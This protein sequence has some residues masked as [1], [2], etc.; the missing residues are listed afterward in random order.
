MI[1]VIVPVYNGED[2]IAAALRSIL[3]QTLAP[4]EVIVVDDGSTDRSAEIASGFGPPIRVLRQANCGTAM[5]TNAGLAEA[6]GELLAFLDADDLWADE[7][8]ALQ[9]SALASNSQLE[10]VFGGVVQFI[11]LD[12][13]VTEPRDIEQQSASFEGI[14][15]NAMLIRRASFD[16]VGPFDATTIADHVEWYSR[17]MRTGI[18]TEILSQ[19]VAFRRIHRNNGTMSRRSAL[20]QD[21]LRIARKLASGRA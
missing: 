7:K 13:R 21:Y 18:R 17:A 19:V 6:K 8:L 10:A 16:R 2:F 3:R 15:K 14:H 11:D 4:H 20:H 1:S 9:S 12:C 5:A